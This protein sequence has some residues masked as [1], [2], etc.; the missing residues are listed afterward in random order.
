MTPLSG[1]T[2]YTWSIQLDSANN[3]QHTYAILADQGAGT[4]KQWWFNTAAGVYNGLATAYEEREKVT[5]AVLRHKNFTWAADVVGNI[6]IGTAQTILN[7]SAATSTV[8]TLDIYG[9][10]TQQQV[11]DYG[12]GSPTHTYNFTYLTDP[13]YVSRFIRN[14]LTQAA[15]TSSAGTITLA[16]NSY[17]GTNVGPSP[18]KLA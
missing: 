3:Y 12:S 15:V 17:D 10:L 7:G 14:R 13:N 18:A 9:N 4:Q 11:Y 1:G 2:Q 6:Y 16:T 8:Q 5:N